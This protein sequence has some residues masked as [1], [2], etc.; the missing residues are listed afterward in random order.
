MQQ[1]EGV[2]LI[3]SGVEKIFF[4]FFSESGNT[5][6]GGFGNNLGRGWKFFGKNPEKLQHLNGKKVIYR[7]EETIFFGLFPK[8]V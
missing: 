4:G 3:I 1:N 6:G 8:G 5:E 2:I 7:S